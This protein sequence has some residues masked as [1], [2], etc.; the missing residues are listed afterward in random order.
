[1]PGILDT[2]DLNSAIA[3]MAEDSQKFIFITS[4]YLMI[5]DRLRK[6]IEIADDRG[7]KT[8]FI[9]GKKELDDDTEKWIKGLHNS[10]IGYIKNVHAKIFMMEL[11]GIVMSMNIYTFSQINNEELGVIFDKRDRRGYKDLAFHAAR[12]I[13]MAEKTHGLWNDECIRKIP[14]GLFGWRSTPRSQT[15]LSCL[16]GGSNDEPEVDNAPEPVDTPLRKCHCIRCN[17]I[18]PSNHPYFYCGRCLDSWSRYNNFS[19][20]EPEG[21]CYICGKNYHASADRPSCLDCYPS[22]RDFIHDQHETMRKMVEHNKNQNVRLLIQ[23]NRVFGLYNDL[24]HSP[25]PLSSLIIHY[26]KI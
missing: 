26:R 6:I 25:L 13:D 15:D 14:S 11:A 17:H 4:P 23:P 8:F 19:Y 22:N 2:H 5:N 24:H 21:H 20:T 9:Y 18:I 7:V 10:S 16:D 12:L 3:H 1:M